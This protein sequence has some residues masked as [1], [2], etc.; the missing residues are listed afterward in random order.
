MSDQSGSLNPQMQEILDFV[1]AEANSHEPSSTD[2]FII[3]LQIE[4]QNY[5]NY[6]LKDHEVRTD[7]TSSALDS[8]TALC[9]AVEKHDSMS[10]PFRI[11]L[12]KN[13]GTLCSVIKKRVFQSMAGKGQ[14]LNVYEL[15]Q[16]QHDLVGFVAL[17]RIFPEIDIN[18]ICLFGYEFIMILNKYNFRL[19]K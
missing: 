8:L 15:N 16:L 5:Q 13:I 17:G 6:L 10:I 19:G 2:S 11:Q 3:S 4:L 18:V 14:I 7:D 1:E 9:Q 12:F